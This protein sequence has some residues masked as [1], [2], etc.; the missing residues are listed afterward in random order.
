MEISLPISK[1]ISRASRLGLNF[2]K[3]RG[4]FILAGSQNP[5]WVMISSLFYKIGINEKEEEKV[6]G[7]KK[8]IRESKSCSCKQS[9]KQSLQMSR[10]LL[11]SRVSTISWED[12]CCNNKCPPLLL[13]SLIYI[14]QQYITWNGMEWNR[15]LVSLAQLSCFLPAVLFPHK[16][17]LIPLLPFSSRG[18]REEAMMVCKHCSAI[19]KILTGVSKFLQHCFSHKCKSSITWTVMKK[20]TL[21]AAWPST[22]T[23]CGI[24]FWFIDKYHA[25]SK[26]QVFLILKL[27]RITLNYSLLKEYLLSFIWWKWYIPKKHMAQK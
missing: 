5:S 18:N 21:I 11:G 23:E 7:L 2:V 15:P 22:G 16:H 25:H 4:R 9:K 6:C 27:K 10:H 19:A 8:K 12:K 1:P 26:M 13:L 3:N 24:F 17:L 20:V 14:V